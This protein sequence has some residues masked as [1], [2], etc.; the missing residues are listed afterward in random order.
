MKT[1]ITIALALLFATGTFAQTTEKTKS[2]VRKMEVASFTQLKVDAE[3]EVMLIDDGQTGSAWLVGEPGYF[4]DISL[5]VK[6]NELVISSKRLLNYRSKITVEVHV[7]DLAKITVEKEAFVFTGSAP[8]RSKKL[9]V[10][11]KDRS[12]TSI[13]ST[14]DINISTEEDM[15]LVFLRRSPGVTVEN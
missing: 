10:L 13:Q 4:D 15:E 14:G 7:K 3:I 1:K 8:I 5:K 9:D 6:N 12:K 2:P 11:I